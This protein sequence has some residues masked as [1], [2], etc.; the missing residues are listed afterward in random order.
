MLLDSVGAG[1]CPVHWFR[2]APGR[3]RRDRR[4]QATVTAVRRVLVVG[5]SGSG[6][7]TTARLIAGEPGIPH[8]ELDALHWGA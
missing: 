3:A 5:S 8:I 1:P 2:R 7:T 4:A 6:K